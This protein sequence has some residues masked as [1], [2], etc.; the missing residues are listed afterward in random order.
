M[1]VNLKEAVQAIINEV[2]T[3]MLEDQERFP[4]HVPMRGGRMTLGHIRRLR[5]AGDEHED[6]VKALAGL[7]AAGPVKEAYG[8]HQKDC[9]C[10]YC[11]AAVTLKQAEGGQ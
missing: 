2:N 6:L 11:S 7:I 9:D 10:A 3:P 5:D 4:D 8:S 1:S